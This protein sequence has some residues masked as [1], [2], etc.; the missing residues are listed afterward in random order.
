MFYGNTINSF[1]SFLDDC[2]ARTMHGEKLSRDEI[3]CL[4]D[5]AP[6]AVQSDMMRSKARDMAAILCQNQG[7]VWSAV[8]IENKSCPMNCEFCSF[9]EKWGLIKEESEWSDE[10]ILQA[11]RFSV[12]QHVSWF[13]LRTTELYGI[14]RLCVLAK[15]ILTEVPGNYHLAVN[16]GELTAEQAKQLKNAGIA[17]VYHTLRLGEGKVTHIK[18]AS[19][20]ATMKAVD[21]AGLKLYHMLEPLGPEHTNEEIA[22]RI[23]AARNCHAVLGGVMARINVK[24]TPFADKEPVHEDRVSQLV[25]IS[26]I[27]GGSSTPDIC[28]VPPNKK[29]LQAGANVVTTEIGSIPRSEQTEHQTAWTGFGIAEAFNLFKE[30][31]YSIP[32]E[33]N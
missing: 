3:L 19:R 30:A 8:G 10:D 29:F 14:E 15:K 22:E 33:K 12:S 2:C 9:G 23:L 5:I 7:K 17:G 25:A 24:G 28:A 16:T 27:C 20:L 11:A 13:T 4:L 6:D 21:E 32:H 26:R 31:G 18:P 1:S